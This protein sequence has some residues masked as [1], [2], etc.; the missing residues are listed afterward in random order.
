[1]K[2]KKGMKL[3][4]TGEDIDQM[5]QGQVGIVEDF[6]DD[7]VCFKGIPGVQHLKDYK[8]ASWKERYGDYTNYG[9]AFK[10]ESLEMMMTT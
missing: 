9:Q 4:R 1:M 5:K 3:V 7:L 8:E 2:L 6:D 10:K